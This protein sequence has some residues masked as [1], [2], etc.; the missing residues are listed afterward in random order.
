MNTYENISKE[1]R[2]YFSTNTF[3]R[4]ALPFDMFVV[5]GCAGVMIINRFISLGSLLGSIAFY[6]FIIGLL[7]SFANDNKKIMYR[8]LFAYAGLH[9]YTVLLY[10]IKFRIVDF[11]SLMD[12]LVFGGIGY[13][14]FKK[15]YS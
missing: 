2:S 9:V 10:V 6:G 5:Y 4:L 11:S 13:L 8:G 3:F 7:L 12:L 14:V 1:L 15:R